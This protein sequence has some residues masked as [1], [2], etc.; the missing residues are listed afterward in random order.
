M[1][2]SPSKSRAHGGS[3]AHLKLEKPRFIFLEGLGGAAVAPA[4]AAVAFAGASAALAGSSTDNTEA[5]ASTPAT[6]ASSTAGSA[7][8]GDGGGGFHLSGGVDGENP[9]T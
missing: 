8:R 3:A 7:A 9:S 2:T 5:G 6:G 1:S 4:G